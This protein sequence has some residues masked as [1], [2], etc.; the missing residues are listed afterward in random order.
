MTGQCFFLLKVGS[1]ASPLFSPL[2]K[3]SFGISSPNRVLLFEQAL[4][5]HLHPPNLVSIFGAA[6]WG[7][8]S[9]LRD[10]ETQSWLL[11]PLRYHSFSGKIYF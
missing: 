5:V 3:C 1:R 9:T 10:K 6:K 2:Y 8:D 7:S 11:D 4:S